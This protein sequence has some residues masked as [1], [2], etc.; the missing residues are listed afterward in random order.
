MVKTTVSIDPIKMEKI[1]AV[2]VLNGKKTDR[3]GLIDLAV[4]IAVNNI[5]NLDAG[6]FKNVN[7]LKL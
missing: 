4:E 7:N 2:A 1:R 6:S 3:Q 5:S